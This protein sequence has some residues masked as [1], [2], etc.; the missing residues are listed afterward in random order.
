MEPFFGINEDMKISHYLWAFCALFALDVERVRV[1]GTA[2]TGAKLRQSSQENNINNIINLTKE[3]ECSA[4]CTHSSQARRMN[5]MSEDSHIG[6]DI[7]KTRWNTLP[8]SAE[9]DIA[10][11]ERMLHTQIALENFNP[12]S[13]PC[14]AN[15]IDEI[16]TSVEA[17]SSHGDAM[18]REE[19]TVMRIAPVTEGLSSLIRL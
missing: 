15:V 8:R 12:D 18:D 14:P 3:D 2:Y 9:E 17:A 16:Q 11:L 7:D 6:Q 1:R 19:A 4:F 5:G 13:R 10:L